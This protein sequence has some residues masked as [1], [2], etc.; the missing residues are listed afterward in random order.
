MTYTKK[1]QLIERIHS[2]YLDFKLS[3]R[4]LSR[5][6]LFHMAGRIAAV[7][8]AYVMLTTE[9][10]WE[11]EEIDFYLLFRDPLTIVADAWES[12]RGEAMS[13][14]GEAMFE[15]STDDRIITQ[16]PLEDLCCQGLTGDVEQT[17]RFT[18]RFGVWE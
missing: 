12:K 3:L 8:E 6:A 16:Y 9:Y 15:L 2:N 10:V 11:E 17:I 4:G 1:D 18:A 7:A 5:D 14:F 13:D